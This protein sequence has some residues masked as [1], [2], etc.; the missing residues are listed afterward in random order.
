MLNELAR[1]SKV[2]M[3]VR[4][5]SALIATPRSRNSS[6]MP[7]TRNIPASTSSRVPARMRTSPRSRHSRT[8]R[9]ISSATSGNLHASGADPDSVSIPIDACASG[10]G[11]SRFHT[12]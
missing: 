8:A 3:V 2:A 5:H 1:A 9:S 12:S 10:I 6:A 7:S 11:P 4:G